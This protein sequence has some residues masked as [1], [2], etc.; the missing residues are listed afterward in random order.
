MQEKVIGHSQYD[1]T[2]GKWCLADLV[3]FCD[4]MTGFVD[5]RR[6][7]DVSHLEFGNFPWPF[8][9]AL[10]FL[11]CVG[12]SSLPVHLGCTRSLPS[13]STISQPLIEARF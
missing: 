13:H 9:S 8:P 4:K 10:C 6:A 5:E 11:S 12:S 2:T 7:V 1:F 3:V